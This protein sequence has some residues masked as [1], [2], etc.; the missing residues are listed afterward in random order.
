V[1]PRI[2]NCTVLNHEDS[3]CPEDRRWAMG[4][5]DQSSGLAKVFQSMEKRS[6]GGSIE[7]ASD[8]VQAGNKAPGDWW[9][10]SSQAHA[11]ACDRHDR[12]TK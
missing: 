10:S 8:L 9:T 5:Y 4:N 6:R 12:R 1:F 3:I 7:R 2:D 11:R